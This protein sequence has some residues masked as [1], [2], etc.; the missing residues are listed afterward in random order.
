MVEEDKQKTIQLELLKEEKSKL[1]SQITA[2]ES[3]IDGLK[4]ERKIW[5][6]ELAQQGK[7]VVEFIAN[8]C[9]DLR[10]ESST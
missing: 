1:I 6:Q 4:A 2:Q 5:G 8:C 3:V 9:Y 10:L 7:L